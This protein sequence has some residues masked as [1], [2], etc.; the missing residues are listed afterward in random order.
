MSDKPSRKPSRKPSHTPSEDQFQIVSQKSKKE[1]LKLRE[2]MYGAFKFAGIVTMFELAFGKG[3]AH[4]ILKGFKAEKASLEENSQADKYVMGSVDQ[5]SSIPDYESTQQGNTG[6][7]QAADPTEHGHEHEIVQIQLP[8]A[9]PTKTNFE[10]IETPAKFKFAYTFG[11]VDGTIIEESQPKRRF[12]GASSP[13]PI[14]ALMNLIYAKEGTEIG[15]PKRKVQSLKPSELTALLNYR[16]SSDGLHESNRVFRALCQNKPHPN[17]DKTDTQK[18]Y[19]TTRGQEIGISERPEIAKFLNK[20]SSGLGSLLPGIRRGVHNAQ[21]AR[22]YFKFLSQLVNYKQNEYLKNYPDEVKQILKYLKREVEPLKNDP[23][24][25]RWSRLKTYLN[26]HLPKT[27]GKPLI[28]SVWGKSG[29]WDGALNYAVVINDQYIV[30]LYTKNSSKRENE[31]TAEDMKKN[32]ERVHQMILTILQNKMPEAAAKVQ[33]TAGVLEFNA[34]AVPK[35]PVNI[36]KVRNKML[37]ESGH[38]IPNSRNIPKLNPIDIEANRSLF[39]VLQNLILTNGKNTSAKNLDEIH[40]IVNQAGLR[41]GKP[42][43]PF[44]CQYKNKDYLFDGERL[45]KKS[46]LKH[47]FSLGYD[48][49]KMGIVSFINSQ[50]IPGTS[51][52]GGHAH[53][54]LKIFANTKVF[55]HKATLEPYFAQKI[56]RL[57]TVAMKRGLLTGAVARVSATHGRFGSVVNNSDKL[58]LM[59]MHGSGFAVDIDPDTNKYATF[60][61]PN[62]Q[63]P[64]FYNLACELGLRPPI[65]WARLILDGS[66][67]LKE[68]YNKEKYIAS[69]KALVQAVGDGTPTAGQLVQLFYADHMHFDDSSQSVSALKGRVRSQLGKAKSIWAKFKVNYSDS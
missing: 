32:E 45:V 25:K 51:S 61:T 20:I 63:V 52:G 30:S 23:E 62:Y 58:P 2:I 3:G 50:E 19:I 13:K 10:T 33:T 65:N 29:R 31:M 4:R 64:E 28:Q 7:N 12:Y 43:I 39:E 53:Q 69:A 36:V 6:Q 24:K 67:K 66:G 54:E 35:R 18:T 27:N 37:R 49:F 34:A 68:P 55:G 40:R 21:T 46:R 60:I 59:S 8:Q 14:L 42:G 56:K 57:E 16:K 17:S 44:M 1:R 48:P 38:K 41:N 5:D 26:K 22:G 15:K 9:R 11:S 47:L